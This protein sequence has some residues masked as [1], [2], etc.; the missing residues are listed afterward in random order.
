MNIVKIYGGLGNQ[1]FQYAFGRALMNRDIDVAFDISWYNT[2]SSKS[3]LRLFLLDKFMTSLWLSEFIN[4]KT[5]HE[6]ENMHFRFF[7][8]LLNE[9]NVNFFGYW[10]NINYFKEILHLLK[11]DFKLR[12]DIKITNSY[13]ELREKIITQQNTIAI[14]VR[15]GDYLT[16]GHYLPSI[17]YY[18]GALK[19]LLDCDCEVKGIYV[20]SD[21]I[22]WCKEQFPNLVIVNEPDYLSFD[23]M[24]LCKHKIISN[25]TFSWW[26][27]M[28]GESEGSITYVPERWRLKESEEKAIIEEGFI[29]N[30]WKKFY[31]DKKFT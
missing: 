29:K 22:L 12:K 3:P 28:I 23:L 31:V 10:Q 27:A 8:E 24:R 9:T 11:Y 15:R 14:H 18:K 6:N 19:E 2:T 1:M 21:D 5:I 30:N 26:A 16:P 13:L 25:S 4:Q 7:P 17:N 20:F